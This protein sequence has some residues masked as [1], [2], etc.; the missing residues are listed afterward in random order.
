MDPRSPTAQPPVAAAGPLAAGAAAGVLAALAL[1][2]FMAAVAAAGGDGAL[3]PLRAAGATFRG[4]GGSVAAG[5]AWG[6][7]LHLA[8]GAAV[9][10]VFAA[11]V[12]PDFPNVSAAG[13]GAG[14]SILLMAL[15][16]S[17]VIPQVAPVLDADMRHR[18]GAWILAHALFGVVLGIAPALRRRRGRPVRGGE[19]PLTLRPR[20]SP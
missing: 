17:L 1:A 19:P 8:A 20:T 15:A 9:G 2:L 5:V 3:A 16:V 11:I 13:L 10:I 6:L 12:P 4:E 7:L 18:G 14:C